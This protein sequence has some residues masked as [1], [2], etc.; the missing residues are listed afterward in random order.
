MKCNTLDVNIII[1]AQTESLLQ[2]PHAKVLNTTCWKSVHWDYPVDTI[3]T[4]Q[5]KKCGA[6]RN[7]HDQTVTYQ[8]FFWPS[9]FAIQHGFDAFLC[10]WCNHLK[11]FTQF[12][13]LIYYT[14]HF[15]ITINVPLHVQHYLVCRC[16]SLFSGSFA[17]Q[18]IEL[19]FR[20]GLLQS[21]KKQ[22]RC[23]FPA[24]ILP[25]SRLPHRQGEAAP[26]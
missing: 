4:V 1:Q 18:I 3:W 25:L 23:L 24:N 14:T 2:F 6:E 8:S 9:F 5:K 19:H 20:A 21:T 7:H 15:H 16:C 22:Q 10:F 13:P 26:K 11:V 17:F 12:E